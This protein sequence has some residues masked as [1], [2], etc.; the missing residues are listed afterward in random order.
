MKRCILVILLAGMFCGCSAEQ[1]VETVADEWVVPV[2]AV[3][4]EISLTLPGEA[5][6]CAVESDSGRLYIGDGYEV[7]VQTLSS[8]D[9]DATLRSVTGFPQK[10]LTVMQTDGGPV[11]RYEFVWA[12]AGEGGQKLGHGVLLDDG[13]YHYCLSILR[14]AEQKEMSQVIWSEVISSFEVV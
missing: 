14:D 7:A 6:V 3:P 4:K 1:T 9:M 12:C 10:D 2:M 13:D 8:G 11:K 5:S